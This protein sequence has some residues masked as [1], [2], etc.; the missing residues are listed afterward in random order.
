MTKQH[1]LRF[2]HRNNTPL[3]VEVQKLL[4]RFPVFLADECEALEVGPPLK[5]LKL[6]LEFDDQI[7]Y[8]YCNGI[9]SGEELLKCWNALTSS[10]DVTI[11]RP[12]ADSCFSATLTATIDRRGCTCFDI[13]RSSMTSDAIVETGHLPR[14]ISLIISSYLVTYNHFRTEK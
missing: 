7:G 13:K 5:R 12:I 10:F 6:S 2:F 11:E 14:D 8:E 9:W 1:V 4:I 3:P